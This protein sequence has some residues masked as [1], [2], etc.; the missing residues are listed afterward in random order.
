[1]ELK[2][3]T[4]TFKPTRGISL[5]LCLLLALF[6]KTAMQDAK[7]SIFYAVSPRDLHSARAV[8]SGAS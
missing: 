3:N 4:H 5:N 2:P 6:Y 1:M 8:S 7:Q